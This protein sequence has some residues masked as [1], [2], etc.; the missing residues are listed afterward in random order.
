MTIIDIDMLLVEWAKSVVFDDEIT[1]SLAPPVFHDD[2]KKPQIH[3]YLIEINPAIMQTATRRSSLRVM[4]G[5]LVT[6]YSSDIQ[7][8]HVI[9][10]DLIFSAMSHE[11]FD[12][13]FEPATTDIW[14][15][16]GQ[17]PQPSF[18]IRVPV[19]H[20]RTYDTQLVRK[21]PVFNTIDKSVLKGTVLGPD[22]IPLTQAQVELPDLNQHMMTGYDGRF[23]FSSVPPNN[24]LRVTAKGR[25]QEVDVRIDSDQPLIVRFDEL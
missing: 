9:L 24:R 18:M 20:E 10:N 13:D 16:T 7:Q 25:V 4:L 21:P 6:V 3:F 22:D 12:V 23:H 19:T 11:L 8:A 5:Y 14:T 17:L 15:V 1:I 2:I